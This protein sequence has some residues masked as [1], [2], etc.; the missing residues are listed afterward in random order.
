MD[1]KAWRSQLRTVSGIKS[2]EPSEAHTESLDISSTAAEPNEFDTQNSE[3]DLAMYDFWY[4]IIN[5][6]SRR[7][8]TRDVDKPPA[9]SVLGEEF[10]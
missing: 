1:M 2:S 6:Y 9:L 3:A 8:P 7:K 4:N 5:E 10:S